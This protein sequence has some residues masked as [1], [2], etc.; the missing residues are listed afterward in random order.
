M[1]ETVQNQQAQ[2]LSDRQRAYQRM[3]GNFDRMEHNMGPITSIVDEAQRRFGGTCEENPDHGWLRNKISCGWSKAALNYDNSSARVRQDLQRLRQGELAPEHVVERIEDFRE[4]KEY[5]VQAAALTAG[6]LTAVGTAFVTS[7]SGPGAILA[8]GALGGSAYEAVYALENIN[9]PDYT[10]DKRL[11]NFATGMSI[12][13]APAIGT[14][15]AQMANQALSRTIGSELVRD[16]AANALG[17]GVAVGNYGLTHGYSE[18]IMRDGSFSE[19]LE[20]GVKKGAVG[21]GIG[22]A[23]G[24]ALSIP[25]FRATAHASTVGGQQ[26]LTFDRA[27]VEQVSAKVN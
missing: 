18:V 13:T 8:G 14:G 25:T 27:V 4:S 22:A 10:W 21:F 3:S 20:N 7:P 17:G 6:G 19:A 5:A 24:G 16:V 15:T 26:A 12:S 23:T 9:N 2:A 1:G 11:A